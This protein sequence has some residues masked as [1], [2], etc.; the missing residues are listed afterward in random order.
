M[1]SGAPPEHLRPGL[2][3][4]ALPLADAARLLS[5]VGGQRVD[6]EMIEA[7]VAVG[8]P[9]NADGTMNLAQYAA[10]LVREQAVR[11]L[12][13]WAVGGEDGSR[14]DPNSLTAE[15]PNSLRAGGSHD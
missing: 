5:A 11:P 9:K 6:V 10:W 15:Q 3:P 8:A 7:D 4:T 12:G 13:Y 1:S 14:S 2:N